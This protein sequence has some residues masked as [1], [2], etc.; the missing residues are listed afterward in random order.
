MLPRVKLSPQPSN[1]DDGGKPATIN[2][3][4]SPNNAVVRHQYKISMVNSGAPATINRR[5][6]AEIVETSRRAFEMKRKTIPVK[7]RKSQLK[8]LL[9]LLV[10]N[11]TVLSEA[12]DNDL[13]KHRHETILFETELI[14]NDIRHLLINLDKYVKRETP[15][16]KPLVN[17]FDGVYVHYEPYGVVLIIGAWNNPL[18]GSLGPLAG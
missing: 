4:V 13:R 8:G 6:I 7:Y 3:D 10:D 14:A 16:D 2:I 1:D 12:V 17:F 18:K 5:S 11:E 9:K 15:E